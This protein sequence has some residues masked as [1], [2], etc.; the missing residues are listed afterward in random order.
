MKWTRRDFLRALS[1]AGA[2][3]ALG[4]LA[5]GAPPVLPARPFGKTGLKLPILGLGGPVDWTTNLPLLKQVFD[6]GV[7]HWD[8][9]PDDAA[10]KGEQG[11]GQYFQRHAGDRPRVFL[12]TKTTGRTA[13]QLDESLHQSLSRLRAHSVDW[14]CLQDVSQPAELTGEIQTWAARAKAQ[15]RIGFFGFSTPTNMAACLAAAAKLGWV[16][17]IQTAYNYRLAEDEELAA[18]LAACAAAGIG[19]TAAD[20]YGSRAGPAGEGST[21]SLDQF[22]DRGFSVPQAKLKVVW[23]NPHVTTLCVPIRTPG[24]LRACL[25]AAL[26]KSPLG[27]PA[28]P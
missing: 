20:P 27:L 2:G 15:R 25:V 4:P 12:A 28:A 26:D 8:T 6:A 21:S 9:A 1:V 24:E 22:V 14:F 18:A 7:A 13:L 11:I 10:G 16:D 19:L 5:A 23:E 17:G 3:S